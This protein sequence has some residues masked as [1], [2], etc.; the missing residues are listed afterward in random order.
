MTP[1]TT[2]R[3]V[4]ESLEKLLYSFINDHKY[5]SLKQ[6]PSITLQ[7]CRSESAERPGSLWDKIHGSSAWLHSLQWLQCRPCFQHKG[8]SATLSS[9]GLRYGAL[10]NYYGSLLWSLPE[11]LAM[12][13]VD[14]QDLSPGIRG[15]GPYFRSSSLVTSFFLLQTSPRPST[16]IQCSV[17]F[18]GHGD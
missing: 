15:R 2:P 11:F 18:K 16:Q 12:L 5:S 13:S 3:N 6:Y 4:E 8:L 7:F 10:A 1:G 14:P 17:P 9:L